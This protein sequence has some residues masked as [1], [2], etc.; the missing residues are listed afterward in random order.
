MLSLSIKVAQNENKTNPHT[1]LYILKKDLK[2]FNSTF[3][4]LLGINIKILYLVNIYGLVKKE[5]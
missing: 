2:D 5:N 4:L 1:Y 3:I